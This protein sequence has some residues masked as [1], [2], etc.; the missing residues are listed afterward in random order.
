MRTHMLCERSMGKHDP[1]DSP[2]TA[3]IRSMHAE[4]LSP[5][6]N[7]NIE[8][9]GCGDFFFVFLPKMIL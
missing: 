7:A 1:V 6:F 5:F 8:R 3:K 2:S 4:A 9:V